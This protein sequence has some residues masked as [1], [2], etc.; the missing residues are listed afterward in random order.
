[1]EEAFLRKI[2]ALKKEKNAVIMAHYY[3][4]ENIQKIADYV[5]DSYYLA[6][7]AKNEKANTIVFC[8]VKFM[9]ES[10]K[11]LNPKKTVLMPDI[12]ADCPMAHMVKDGVIEKMRKQY[13]DLAVVCYVNSSVELK[14][15]SDVCVTSSNAVKIVK[16]LPNKNVFFIPDENLGRFVKEQVPEKNVILNDGYCPRHKQISLESLNELKN[17]YPNA[18]VLTHPECVEEVVKASDFVGS[19]AEIIEYA[20]QSKSRQ[21]I[22]CT[23]VG[24]LYPLKENDPQK[25]FYF[26][27]PT[28]VCLDMKLNTLEKIVDVLESGKNQI[29]LSEEQ[30]NKALL[31]LERMLELAK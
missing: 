14:A 13:S 25:E 3:T 22:I 30:I 8:G 9:G 15:K 17:K 16:N 18:L 21:F 11:I 20:K 12:S 24:V 10:A 5:G 19:T 28:P 4:D 23:E 31:P 7:V 2:I 29:T 1:M 26:V 6:K 27:S